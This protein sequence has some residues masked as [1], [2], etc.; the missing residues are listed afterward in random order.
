MDYSRAYGALYRHVED[1]R[2][3]LDA[4]CRAIYG[5]G[6]RCKGVNGRNTAHA[7]H[8]RHHRRSILQAH[9]RLEGG[10]QAASDGH[11]GLLCS[12]LCR[13]ADPHQ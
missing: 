13:S 6:I 8:G 10:G 5:H 2:A 3:G 11:T 1:G 9:S 7:L 4:A 12:H